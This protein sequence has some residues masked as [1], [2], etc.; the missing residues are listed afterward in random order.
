MKAWTQLNSEEIVAKIFRKCDNSEILRIVFR[1]YCKNIP[2]IFSEPGA[3]WPGGATAASWWDP[4]SSASRFIIIMINK[5]ITRFMI[6]TIVKQDYNNH[7]VLPSVERVPGKRP[8]LVQGG[9]TREYRGM[10]GDFISLSRICK[11]W[12]SFLGAKNWRIF[13]RN[14]CLWRWPANKST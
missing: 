1:K 13:W 12:L 2:K 4:R 3:W 9:Q 14:T 6:I 5:I 10:G 8:P 7:Y 11:N